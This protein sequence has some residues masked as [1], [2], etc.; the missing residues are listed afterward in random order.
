MAAARYAAI[1]MIGGRSRIST[2]SAS[3]VAGGGRTRSELERGRVE[4][5]ETGAS[6]RGR[7]DRERLRAELVERAVAVLAHAEVDLR[8][9]VAAEALDD[10]DEQAELDAPPFDER[11]HLER[12]AP[13]RVLAAERLHDV[14]ELREQQRQQRPGDELGDAAAAGRRAVERA[15]VARLHEAR[16]RGR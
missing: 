3:S 6:Q 13:A 16:R 12:V 9:R 5:H 7:D 4:V 10:V 1:V 15:R 14:G 8:D 2:G 11:Q